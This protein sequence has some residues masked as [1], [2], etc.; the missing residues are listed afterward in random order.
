MFDSHELHFFDPRAEVRIVQQRLPHWTQAGVVTFITFRTHDSMPRDV[1]LHWLAERNAWLAAHGISA[2]AGEPTWHLVSQ[3]PP[4]LQGE[5]HRRFS[6][7]WHDELDQCHGAC[8]LRAREIAD[9]V[10]QG[11]E[12]FNGTRY[13]LTDYVIMPNHVHVLC[14]FERTQEVESQCQSWKRYTARAINRTLGG[15]GRFWQQEAFDHLVRSDG[16]FRYLRSYIAE[17]PVRARLREGEFLHYSASF[18][19]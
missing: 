19:T 3:F 15:S 4:A 6:A 12:H 1:V 11:L 10:A 5:F 9:L 7:R 14:A 8:Q 16:Q 17:N 18:S 2:A 13:L